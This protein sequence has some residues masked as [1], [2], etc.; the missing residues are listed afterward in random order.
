MRNSHIRCQS[1]CWQMPPPF[2]PAHS[3]FHFSGHSSQEQQKALHERNRH[4]V[5]REE[6]GSTAY[7]TR[8]MKH[9]SGLSRR[10]KDEGAM[11]SKEYD[12]YLMILLQQH[13]QQCQQQQHLQPLQEHLPLSPQRIFAH[14]GTAQHAHKAAALTQH[15]TEGVLDDPVR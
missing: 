6:V 5:S 2:P 15:A 3:R 12:G 13:L 11:A 10:Q 9:S 1:H 7:L 8:Q 4:V 14:I